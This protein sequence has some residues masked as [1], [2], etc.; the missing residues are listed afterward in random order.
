MRCE[1]WLRNLSFISQTPVLANDTM[2]R[3][4]CCRWYMGKKPR[5]R[6]LR[7]VFCTRFAQHAQCMHANRTC[8]A[9]FER[10]ARSC[11]SPPFRC[12]TTCW[13]AEVGA[14]L[15]PTYRRKDREGRDKASMPLLLPCSTWTCGGVF[16][17]ACFRKVRSSENIT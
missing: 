11:L 4:H 1:V 6:D 14:R 8:R 17:Y 7:G 10:E 5:V 15:G 16:T 13:L 2:Y 9:F 3:K 12:S